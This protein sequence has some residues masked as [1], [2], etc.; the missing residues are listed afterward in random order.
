MDSNTEISDLPTEIIIE[1]CRCMTYDRN[2]ISF[3]STCSFFYS[4]RTLIF[5]YKRVN[6]SKIMSLSY[7]NNFKRVSASTDDFI[8][9]RG[10]LKQNKISQKS[11]LPE[12]LTNLEIK[13]FN[14]YLQTWTRGLEGLTSLSLLKKCKITVKPGCIPSTVTHLTWETNQRL[15]PGVLPEGLKVLKLDYYFHSK[16]ALP[17]TLKS[18]YVGRNFN[19]QLHFNEI[20]EGLLPEGLEVLSIDCRMSIR[21]NALPSTLKKIY[22]GKNYQEL[23]MPKR[24]PQNLELF[25]VD[26][27]IQ[28]EKFLQRLPEKLHSLIIGQKSRIYEF[29]LDKL[30]TGLQYLSLDCQVCSFKNDL[31]AEPKKIVFGKNFKFWIDEDNKGYD[32]KISPDVELINM[33]KAKIFRKW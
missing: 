19:L 20:Y 25:S 13:N 4:M 17:S 18:F 23:K 26:S 15:I 6:L 9:L 10:Y 30:P 27:N 28:G 21:E 32:L 31:K 22:F 16:I 2:I 3:L 1:I 14:G 8:K 12:N 11:L 33:S 29:F 24:F 7:Y 5:Y